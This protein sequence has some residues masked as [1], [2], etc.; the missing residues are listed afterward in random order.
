M[1]TPSLIDI[2]RTDPLRAELP[3]RFDPVR[4]EAGRRRMADLWWLP[5]DGDSFLCVDEFVEDGTLT[6]RVDAP[7][8]DPSSDVD[9]RLV[10]HHLDLRV[11]RQERTESTEPQQR[12]TEVRYGTFRRSLPVPRGTSA[13]QIAA[14]YHDGVL[15]IRVPAG[16]SEHA[17]KIAIEQS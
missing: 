7:G 1:R 3:R 6:V 13:E 12:R 16:E 4:S 2:F 15:E 14:S 9:L 10:D 11:T 17:E 5:F 8:I